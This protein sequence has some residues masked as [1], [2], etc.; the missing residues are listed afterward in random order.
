MKFLLTKSRK[1]VKILQKYY[2]SINFLLQYLK[3]IDNDRKKLD[4][5]NKLTNEE[6]FIGGILCQEQ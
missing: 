2:K 6:Y 5:Y 1:Y 4:T 3:S